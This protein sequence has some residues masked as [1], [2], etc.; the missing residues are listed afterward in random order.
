MKTEDTFKDEINDIGLD[1]F[2]IHYHTGK[3]IHLYRNYARESKYQQIIIDATGSVVSNFK[4]M[5][6]K[7]QI[8]FSFMKL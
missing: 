2:F 8:L 4:N 7:K 3:Q 5:V 6:W 1:Q